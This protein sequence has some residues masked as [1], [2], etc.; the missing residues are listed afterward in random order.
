MWRQKAQI[1][2]TFSKEIQGIEEPCGSLL[3]T[4]IALTYNIDD[5]D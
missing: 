2:V 5:A 3:Y 4:V 1:N